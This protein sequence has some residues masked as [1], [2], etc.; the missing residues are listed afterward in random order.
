[1][2][3]FVFIAIFIS[4]KTLHSQYVP[5]DFVSINDSNLKLIDLR[6]SRYKS[7]NEQYACIEEH[8]DSIGR[9][10][11]VKH[12]NKKDPIKDVKYDFS[13]LNTE[14]ILTNYN[15]DISLSDFKLQYYEERKYD[16]NKAL[17]YI[18]TSSLFNS[19]D[20]YSTFIKYNYN[21]KNLVSIHYDHKLTEDGEAKTVRVDSLIYDKNGRLTKYL[22]SYNKKIWE[23]KY[24]LYN[25]KN[26]I[27]RINIIKKN[28]CLQ[29]A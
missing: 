15:P 25:K 19:G 10:F 24:Y 23:K 6:T 5:E 29:T 17:T 7:A 26:Q 12:L 20:E 27:V 8:F 14:K 22:I 11:Y 4:I 3:I 13:V 1:M 2:K 9:I 16:Q 18:K 21:D 28:E